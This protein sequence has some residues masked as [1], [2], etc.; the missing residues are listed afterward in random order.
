MLH[1]LLTDV[2]HFLGRRN[3]QKVTDGLVLVCGEKQVS[4]VMTPVQTIIK[5]EKKIICN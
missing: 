3:V 1:S 2:F 4:A 5:H